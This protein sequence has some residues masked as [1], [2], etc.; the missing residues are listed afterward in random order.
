MAIL[1]GLKRG[2]VELADVIAINKSDGDLVPA[3]RRI[4]AEYLSALKFVRPR[5]AGWRVP[6]LRCSARS[7]D[8]LPELWQTLQGFRQRMTAD[9]QLA[10]RRRRQRAVWLWAQI[11]RAVVDA[12]RRTPAVGRLLARLEGEVAAGRLPP[13][14]A[15][16]RL[17]ELFLDGT[18]NGREERAEA[19]QRREEGERR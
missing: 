3:A 15:A 14:A 18:E 13:G 10:A 4:Q 9:G 12:F 8:G 5:L 16:D 6:V 7:G 1:Q 11:E 2:I 19:D 17:V